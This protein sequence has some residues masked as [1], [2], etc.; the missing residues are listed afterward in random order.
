MKRII[1]IT[2]LI[3][4]MVFCYTACGESGESA[5]PESTGTD[6]QTEDAVQEETAPAEL[7][8]TESG[9][10]VSDD[11]MYFAFVLENPSTDTAFELPT[12]TVTAY[13]ESGDVLGTEEQTMLRLQ[14]GDKQAIAS[15][16]SCNGGKPSKVD[17]DIDM[18]DK[19]KPDADA[20]TASTLEITGDKERTGEYGDI[21]ITGKVKNNSS[22]DTDTVGVTAIYKSG[23]EIVYGETTFVDNLSAGQEKAFEVNSFDVPDH[24]SYELYAFNWGY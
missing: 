6:T 1:G 4:A 12:V 3:L 16:M 5:A 20:I 19:V 17:F 21:T 10:H 7:Q 18:G 15:L 9:Y 23:G 22:V 24:D 2:F 8:I 11:Y 13:D 14:P